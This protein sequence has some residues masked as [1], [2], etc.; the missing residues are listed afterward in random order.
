MSAG[1]DQLG[2]HPHCLPSSQEVVCRERLSLP[3]LRA[4][5]AELLVTKL[6]LGARK[7]K[8]GTE[9]LLLTPNVKVTGKVL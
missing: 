7:A 8:V 3:V 1:L 5:L 6:K 2:K 4:E 9:R